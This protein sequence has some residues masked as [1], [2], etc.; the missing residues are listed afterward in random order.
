MFTLSKRYDVIVAG[1]GHAGIEAAL[2]AS[3]IGCSTLLLTQNLDTIGQMSC[4]PAIG[5]VGKG[6]IVREIDALGGAMG[7]NADATGIH[8]RLL[9]STKGAS[10]RAPRAQCDKKAYQFRLKAVVESAKNLDVK[11]AGVTAVIAPAGQV[12]AVETDLGMRVECSAVVVT[13]GTFLRAMLHVGSESRSGG[14][15][16]DA[17]SGLSGSLAS[18]GFEV[19]R[20]KTGTPCRLNGGT[21][22]FSRCEMQRGDETPTFFSFIHQ[23][24]ASVD[25]VFTLNRSLF[26]VE[27][28]PCWITRTTAAT[29]DIVRANLRRSPL[30]SGRISGTGPRYCPSI[31]DKI[32]KFADKPTHQIFLEPEGRH[33]AEF[34]VN[35]AS[36]SLPLDVQAAFIRTI[37]G[38]ENAEIMRPGY[39][40]EYDFFPPTQLHPTLETKNIRRLYFAGQVNG[41]SG[42]EEAAGQG[43][44]AG[45]NAAL[46]VAGRDQLLLSRDDSY[47]GVMIDDLVTRGADEPYRMFTSR[48]ENRLELRHDTADQ[49]LTPQGRR[50]GLVDDERWMQFN[51]KVQDLEDLRTAVGAARINGITLHQ[52]L[53]QSDF[54]ISELPEVVRQLAPAELW[55]LVTAEARFDGYIQRQQKLTHRVS[56]S[57]DKRIPDGIEF[58][59]IP[60]LRR[61]TRQ[62]L[63][64]VRPTSLRQLAT[65]RGIT[66]ADVSIISIWLLSKTLHDKQ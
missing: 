25:S 18:L 10:A 3:R 65:M 49:R 38:C 63:V 30:Y 64:S 22:D 58:E 66:P 55:S 29:H 21:I 51:K 24:E 2:A 7:S 15:M 50:V 59:S 8:F 28:L 34:Y 56:G 6:H 11:Q 43:L 40:V 12:E 57:L 19:A 5:G 9:N 41:T 46:Q 44:I 20:F 33:T 60:G 35:G 1:A 31:E 45:A 14:R 62:R 36:T 39:A 16:A 37:P 48:A 4:N 26:H 52:R 53:K 54:K 13:S 32:V 61:E 17:T 27:Q 47:I 42:Y 23:Q